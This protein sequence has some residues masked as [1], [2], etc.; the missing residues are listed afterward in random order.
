MFSGVGR[1]CR[2][3]CGAS[4]A[5]SGPRRR[6][7]RPSRRA[8][9]RGSGVA[10]GVS[11]HA[12]GS[13]VTP[14]HGSSSLWSSSAMGSVA[15]V[16]TELRTARAAVWSAASNARASAASSPSPILSGTGRRRSIA[17]WSSAPRRM[18][19]LVGAQG[20]G[21]DDG[22]QE[23]RPPS[24]PARPL[25]ALH[26]RRRSA[27]RSQWPG[28]RPRPRPAAPPLHAPT[29]PVHRRNRLPSPMPTPP[30]SSRSRATAITCARPNATRKANALRSQSSPGCPYQ[31]LGTHCGS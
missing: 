12:R 19:V 26:H 17:G 29:A 20:L 16:T 2:T 21:K 10:P 18:L 14:G 5:R 23:P 31:K 22:C 24:H 28:N 1:G 7:H 25:F 4:R 6:W 13:L 11:R 3:S 8:C 27:P 15:V 9:P 30:T